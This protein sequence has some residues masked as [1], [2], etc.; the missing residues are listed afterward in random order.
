MSQDTN[1]CLRLSLTTESSD[2]LKETL[3]EGSWEAIYY[4]L[5]DNAYYNLPSVLLQR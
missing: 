3:Y 2:L 1:R 5:L 4:K